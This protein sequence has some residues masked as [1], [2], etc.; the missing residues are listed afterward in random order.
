[1]AGPGKLSLL[2]VDDDERILELAEYAAKELGCF[3]PIAM[4]Q[5][6]E[7]ALHRLE[8]AVALPDVILTD[9]SM[10]VMDGFAL[11]ETLKRNPATRHIPVVMFSSSGVLYDQEHAM[12]VG[13]E[14]F[15]PKPGTLA[16]LNDVLVH[17]AAIARRHPGP[18]RAPTPAGPVA[19]DDAFSPPIAGMRRGLRQPAKLLLVDDRPANLL[20]LEAVLEGPEYQLLRAQ[21]GPEAIERVRTNPD[22]ALILLDVQ[23]PGMDGMETLRRVKALP[24]GREIPTILITAIF[25]DDAF[26]KQ[27]YEAGAVDY[28]SKPFDPDILR[29]KVGI[30]AS[31]RRKATWLKDKERQLRES[32]EL[33]RTGRKL[34]AILESLRVGVI[35]TDAQG[36]VCQTND[37]VMKILQSV[38]Q[39][40][41]DCYGEFLEWWDRDGVVLK[42][43]EGPLMQALMKGEASHNEVVQ[44]T[45]LDRSAKSIF[46]STS[47][48]R[49]LDGHIVGAVLVMQDVT[50]HDEIDEGV[51][52]RIV[53]LVSL[54][55]GFEES[56][57][58]QLH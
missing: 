24:H 22:V 56:A 10:P 4:A 50:A 47:P 20:A 6:G 30:Y 36:R 2:I 12:A 41:S 37:E 16:G 26:V 8:G 34:S 18:V 11:V 53:D 23:M 42:G 32:E 7:D 48:L 52:R 29:L 45:C 43:R 31:F 49:G 17:V 57:A 54:S 25:T 38:D 27:G 3:Q 13:C 28:F 39:L 35:I 21:S 19:L 33:L 15:L 55:V 58:P 1:M 5:H 40:R 9:L 46:A 44:L 14:A 51:A